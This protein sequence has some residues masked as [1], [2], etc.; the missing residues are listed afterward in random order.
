MFKISSVRIIFKYLIIL[1]ENQTV[2]DYTEVIK[3]I[4]FNK[5]NNSFFT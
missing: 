4:H 1:V 5:S 2:M 3:G